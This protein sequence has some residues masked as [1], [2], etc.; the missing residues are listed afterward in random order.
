MV[1]VGVFTARAGH[2]IGYGTDVGPAREQMHCLACCY[3][4]AGQNALLTPFLAGES[5]RRE[6]AIGTRQ[7]FIS[8]VYQLNGPLLIRTLRYLCYNSVPTAFSTF[9]GIA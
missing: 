7:P 1:A 2:N 5:G 8:V 9:N 3:V 4:R 6:P